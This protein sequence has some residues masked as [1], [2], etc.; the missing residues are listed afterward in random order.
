MCADCFETSMCT[1]IHHSLRSRKVIA[2]PNPIHFYALLH[3]S[4]K[5]TGLRQTLRDDRPLTNSSLGRVVLNLLNIF[6]GNRKL[7]YTMKKTGKRP[8]GKPRRRWV[9]NINMDP[10]G[11]G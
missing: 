8:L 2:E 4:C 11:S 3:L 9:D 10:T 1:R 5:V 7:K 6:P